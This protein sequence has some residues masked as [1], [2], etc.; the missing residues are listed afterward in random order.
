M[1]CVD[2]SPA[3]L[4]GLDQLERHGQAMQERGLGAPLVTF[5]PWRTVAEVDSIG[6]AITGARRG[7]GV[8]VAPSGDGRI[9]PA[10]WSA[11]HAPR[12]SGLT[13][14]SGSVERWTARGN[15]SHETWH[16]GGRRW[17]QGGY[18]ATTLSCST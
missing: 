1:G 4:I 13:M 15:G 12:H 9:N 8:N 16:R 17:L 18:I 10:A 6:T 14:S 5:V 2:R 3:L 11:R 7:P